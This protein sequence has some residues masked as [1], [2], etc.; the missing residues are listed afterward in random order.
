MQI[1]SAHGQNRSAA[2]KHRASGRKVRAALEPDQIAGGTQDGVADDVSRS[3]GSGIDVH[4]IPGLQVAG[5]DDVGKRQ[6]GSVGRAGIR[7]VTS[8][9]GVDIP[10]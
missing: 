1:F 10:R 3:I 5:A 7:V 4:R 6:L 2:G 9:A 8:C